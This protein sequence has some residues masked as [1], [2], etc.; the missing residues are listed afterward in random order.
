V[1]LQRMLA[2]WQIYRST[3]MA[4]LVAEATHAIQAARRTSGQKGRLQLAQRL[5]DEVAGIMRLNFWSRL[6][7]RV[8]FRKKGLGAVSLWYLEPDPV[9]EGER[10]SI[11]LCAIP[12]APEDVRKAV[13]YVK[14]THNPVQM[15]E[16]RLQRF[17]R[18]R[19]RACR[20]GKV[21]LPL[22]LNQLERFEYI[23][24]AGW[25]HR[26]SE[27]H[28]FAQVDKCVAIDMTWIERLARE[29][30]EL[31]TPNVS[32]WLDFASLCAFPVHRSNGSADKK[33]VIGVLMAFKNT[34]YGITLEDQDSVFILAC[35]LGSVFATQS[36]V[37]LITEKSRKPDEP[38]TETRAALVPGQ[39]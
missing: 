4:K 7:T 24:L 35:L 34:E 32:Q 36:A 11:K 38:T 12:G 13:A 17:E 19:Q 6:V 3:R 22:L 10:F 30:R 9:V 31:V 16:E 28:T 29:K 37:S 27:Q 2:R 33:V 1:L 14:E 20:G 39:R 5:M 15:T 23:S 26:F 25:I 21:N 8:L 18:V